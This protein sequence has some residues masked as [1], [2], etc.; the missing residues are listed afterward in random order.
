LVRLNVA[1]AASTVHSLR[2]KSLLWVFQIR[3]GMPVGLIRGKPVPQ[4]NMPSG[5]T[6]GIVLKQQDRAKVR[7]N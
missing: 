4:K 7:F 6:R 1:S 5:S 3:K 2:M